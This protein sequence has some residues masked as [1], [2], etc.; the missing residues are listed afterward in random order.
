MEFKANYKTHTVSVKQVGPNESALNGTPIGIGI[1]EVAKENDT[2]DILFGQY[3]YKVVFEGLP[4]LETTGE[5]PAKVPKMFLNG[6]LF[7][8]DNLLP[9]TGEWISKGDL[10]HIYVYGDIM[11]RAKANVSSKSLIYYFQTQKMYA[12]L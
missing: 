12:L 11:K 1:E 8:K 3:R 5:K 2:V 4:P 6:D 7:K 10:L 9:K